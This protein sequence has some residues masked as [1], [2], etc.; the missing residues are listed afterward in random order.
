MLDA[1]PQTRKIARWLTE[2]GLER[3]GVTVERAAHD[4]TLEITG[5][6]DP[7]LYIPETTFTLNYT[8]IFPYVRLATH[9]LGPVWIS[10]TH[11]AFV[12]LYDPTFVSEDLLDPNFDNAY[13]YGYTQEP[14]HGAYDLTVRHD[15]I[16]L[17]L[18]SNVVDLT[19]EAYPYA[20]NWLSEGERARLG[21]FVEL[22]TMFGLSTTRGTEGFEDELSAWQG[23]RDVQLVSSGGGLFLGMEVNPLF[24]VDQPISSSSRLLWTFG[25]M[26]RLSTGWNFSGWDYRKDV[27]WNPLVEGGPMVGRVQVPDLEA[28]LL[29]GPMVGVSLA[30]R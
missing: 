17:A 15:L 7:R 10:Y 20:V 16:G 8:V 26:S 30:S 9:L 6:G 11:P 12:A 3:A 14:S 2:A 1:D 24:A 13:T 4:G 28:H 21:F 22:A 5:P 18:R 19:S 23:G 29:V 25:A 27:P